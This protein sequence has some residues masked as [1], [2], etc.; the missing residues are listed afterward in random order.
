MSYLTF[1]LTTKSY[2]FL[3]KTTK[4]LFLRHPTG[5][6]VVAGLYTVAIGFIIV[7]FYIL[8]T[9]FKNLKVYNMYLLCPSSLTI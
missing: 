9:D 8:S 7:Y 1:G 4:L 3:I 6:F 5:F 2:E